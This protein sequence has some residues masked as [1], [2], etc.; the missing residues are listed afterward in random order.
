M[1]DLVASLAASQQ[2]RLAET[3]AR[4][5]Q[6][7]LC[8]LEAGV[9]KCDVQSGWTPI[10]GNGKAGCPA[11]VSGQARIV[12]GRP[13]YEEPHPAKASRNCLSEPG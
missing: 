12:P 11:R 4:L 1:I 6:L 5:R 7:K 10:A 9:S 13:R 8:S 2:V 3:A